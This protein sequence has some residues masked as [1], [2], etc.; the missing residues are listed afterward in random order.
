MAEMRTFQL[1]AGDSVVS[2]HGELDEAA[3]AALAAEIGTHAGSDV[4]VDLLRA[5]LVDLDVV[6]ALVERAGNVTF[7]A[8][9]SLLQA[10]QV[11]GLRRY[12]RVEPTLNA[13]LA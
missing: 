12:V 9:R 3:G 11:V 6:D 13:A 8:E 7:V 2:M 5:D 4:I 1:P 10:L